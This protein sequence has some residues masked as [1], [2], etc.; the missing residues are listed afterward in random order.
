MTDKINTIVKIIERAEPIARRHH[1][2]LD[3]LTSIMDVEN[4]N[5]QY[6]LDLDAWLAADDSNFVHDFFGIR[7]NINRETGVLDNCFVPR[8]YRQVEPVDDGGMAEERER[9]P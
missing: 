4:A 8:F 6:P 1:I 9:H 2:H 3:R 7:A 5:D